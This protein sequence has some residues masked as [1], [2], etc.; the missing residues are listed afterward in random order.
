VRCANLCAPRRHREWRN[1]SAPAIQT[2]D[3]LRRLLL[4]EH[5]LVRKRVP[6]F[7]DH[8]PS[9]EPTLTFP[10][11]SI[12]GGLFLGALLAATLLP[13]SSEAMLA[14]LLAAGTGEPWVLFLVA[15]GGNTSG[16][17]INWVLGRAIERFRGR[18][19]F[20]ITPAQYESASRS[21]R[22]YGSWA[23]LFAWLPF[24]GDPLTVVAG[25]LRVPFLRFV[26]L[27]A[28]GKAA[29]YA[30]VVAGVSWWVS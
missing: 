30:A 22:R 15:T 7:R 5:D 9:L 6:D 13:G 29:R 25:A 1:P 28:I 2:K 4:F 14:A 24:V 19:W 17:V 26:I 27:V 23:L 16:S 20:P 11:L 10:E 21:F 8:A 12:Y 3:A 18:R